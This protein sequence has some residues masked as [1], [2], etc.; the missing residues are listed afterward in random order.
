MGI[1]CRNCPIIPNCMWCKKFFCSF[2]S[3]HFCEVSLLPREQSCKS[4]LPWIW[5]VRTLFSLQKKSYET[6]IAQKETSSSTILKRGEFLWDTHTYIHIKM[7][8]RTTLLDA[9]MYISCQ[10]YIYFTN[11][12]NVDCVCDWVCTLIQK[13]SEIPMKVH[14]NKLWGFLKLFYMQNNNLYLLPALQSP[15][16]KK[17]V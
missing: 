2:F 17:H 15:Y 7:K 14:I 11:I 8:M 9:P 6:T 12:L 4:T 13:A 1:T 3:I 10:I 5:F 16:K